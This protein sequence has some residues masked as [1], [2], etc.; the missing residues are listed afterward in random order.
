MGL[1]NPS[2]NF[3]YL[4]VT[5]GFL[6]NK[7]QE[8]KVRGYE[9]KLVG[10]RF[11]DDD[12]Q[13]KPVPKVKLVMEDPEEEK[14]ALITFHAEGWYMWTFCQRIL[15][16]DLTKPFILGVSGPDD[17]ESKM[18]FCWMKQDGKKIEKDEK[19]PLPVKEKKG[20]KE[21]VNNEAAV[22]ASEKIINDIQD[23]VGDGK[24][25]SYTDQ[26]MEEHGANNT[27]DDDAPF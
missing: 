20:R 3:Q 18:S 25:G 10:I 23:I 21:V 1:F 16:I 7:K 11:E 19:F 8:I 27:E 26:Q 9:G 24:I 14:K 15:S 5:C 22:A 2:G 13:G 4:N 6:V 12:Y 17:P